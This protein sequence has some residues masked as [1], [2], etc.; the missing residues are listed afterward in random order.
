MPMICGSSGL[1]ML[2]SYF[3]MMAIRS[4][5]WNSRRLIATC[6]L[7]SVCF[8]GILEESCPGGSIKLR[9]GARAEFDSAYEMQ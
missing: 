2:V 5:G 6:V 9:L 7:R 3:A 8:H 1:R 4:T